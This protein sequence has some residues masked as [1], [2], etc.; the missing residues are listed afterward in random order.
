MTMKFIARRRGGSQASLAQQLVVS[1]NRFLRNPAISQG[2]KLRQRLSETQSPSVL[3]GRVQYFVLP[4][5]HL[6]V[7][8]SPAKG[9]EWSAVVHHWI[10]IVW[11]II[12]HDYFAGPAQ[13]S[14]HRIG[15]AAVQ[16]AG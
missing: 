4:E 15:E 2:R 16:M 5:F 6:D 13:G 7:R 3:S 1:T 8:Q 10:Q 9:M 12:P 11:L 14:E